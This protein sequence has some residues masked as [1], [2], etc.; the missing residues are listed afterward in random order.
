MGAQQGEDR[1]V[2]EEAAAWFTRLKQSSVSEATVEEFFAWRGEPANAE[3]YAEVVARWRQA[4]RVRNDPE[5]VALTEA[6]L[7]KEPL[8]KRFRRLLRRPVLPSSL[9]ALALGGLL[10]VLLVAQFRGPTYETEVGAQQIIRLD[11]G[12]VLRLNTDSKVA[13]GFGRKERTVRLLRG[14]GFFE[15]A[16][17]PDRPFIVEAGATRVRALGTKFDVRRLR[18][19]TQV[20]LLE[21]RVEVSRASRSEAWTLRPNQQVTVNGAVTGPRPADAAAASSWTTG[22][23]RFHETPLAAA[24]AEM[25]RYSRTKIVLDADH[26]ADIRVNGMFETGNT[27]AFLSAVTELFGL[28]AATTSDGVVLRSRAA[29]SAD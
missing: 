22:R 9:A 25:N 17:D 3:A 27:Q 12:S 14:E 19:G 15:V 13:I 21:G 6:A 20:T 24:V 11:D 26:L 7:R 8:V 28:E 1:R 5:L 2:L 29:S 16:H 23:V 10:V 4:D 18:A